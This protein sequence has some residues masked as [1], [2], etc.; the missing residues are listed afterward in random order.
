M[1]NWNLMNSGSSFLKSRLFILLL[2]LVSGNI[3]AQSIEQKA[4]DF[5]LTN[6][7]DSIGLK[8]YVKETIYYSGY[9][10]GSHSL[11]H[12]IAVNKG[13]YFGGLDDYPKEILKN[14]FPDSVINNFVSGSYLDSID[15]SNKNGEDYT[16]QIV[17]D[18]DLF[19]VCTDSL[20]L[21]N[22]FQIFIDNSILYRDF[23]YVN[24]SFSNGHVTILCTVRFNSEAEPIEFW[25]MLLG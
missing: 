5:I 21:E 6:Y 3:K 4:V 14:Y 18:N 9:T 8:K 7:L 25:Y 12:W 13:E 16:S 2:L 23:E 15:I 19:Y 11:A 22:N 20:Y 24:I 17:I 1:G 10:S